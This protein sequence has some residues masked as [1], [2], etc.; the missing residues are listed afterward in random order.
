MS[1]NA[2]PLTQIASPA[3][4]DDAVDPEILKLTQE[5]IQAQKKEEKEQAEEKEDEKEDED[6]DD[7]SI[8]R[9]KKNPDE[10]YNDL[11]A[12]I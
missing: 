9:P 2:L 11:K 6:D 12:E 10:I 8:E 4:S 5:M 7:E 3:R 1:Q